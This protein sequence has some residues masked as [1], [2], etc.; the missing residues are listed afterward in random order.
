MTAVSLQATPDIAMP[1]PK[2]ISLPSAD[3]EFRD[4]TGC[5]AG[6]VELP[7]TRPSSLS[8]TLDLSQSRAHDAALDILRAHKL[9]GNF[10]INLEIVLKD[11]GVLDKVT[12]QIESNSKPCYRRDCRHVVF[13]PNE[14][15]SSAVF[16]E[17]IEAIR[18]RIGFDAP[19][20]VSLFRL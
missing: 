6:R 3:G 14:N 5:V 1:G 11:I 12:Y 18:A 15:V 8:C 17:I 7:A 20:W 16:G 13:K 2:I 4:R 9:T 19:W 10:H